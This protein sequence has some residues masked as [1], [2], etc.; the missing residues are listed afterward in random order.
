MPHIWQVWLGSST[1]NNWKQ[2]PM[3]E[4][5]QQFIPLQAV[6]QQRNKLQGTPL[7]QHGSKEWPQQQQQQTALQQNMSPHI[8]ARVTKKVIK[9]TLI[10][11]LDFRNLFGSH[12]EGKSYKR[13]SLQPTNEL[14]LFCGGIA[15]VFHNFC[16]IVLL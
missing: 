16:V 6:K 12:L 5:Q 9:R 1:G 7:Q 15:P 14:R 2:Q 3:E 11:N 4:S 13:F 8:E 10:I